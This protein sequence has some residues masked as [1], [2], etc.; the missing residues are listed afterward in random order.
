M[1]KF[2]KKSKWIIG[3]AV[4]EIVLFITILILIILTQIL[5][6]PHIVGV[7]SFYPPVGG[8]SFNPPN[9]YLT[10]FGALLLLILPLSIL[11]LLIS[12]SNSIL[13]LRINLNHDWIEKMKLIFGITSFIL[14]ISFILQ[15][16]FVHKFSKKIFKLKEEG[17]KEGPKIKSKNRFEKEIYLDNFLD[18]IKKSKTINSMA[19]SAAVFFFISIILLVI[20]FTVSYTCVFVAIP[21]C[22]ITII[23]FWANSF[24]ILVIDS[25]DEKINE[26]RLLWGFLSLF[27]FGFVTQFIFVNLL[28]SRINVLNKREKEKLDLENKK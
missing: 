10:R 25:E 13:I 26:L 27:L 28:N 12:V 22:I 23:L 1:E 8:G 6:Y 15:L 19:I 9:I 24:L 7:D 5:N 21:L 3:L 4:S 20:G 11:F 14:P 16:V 2:E 17:W 18:I